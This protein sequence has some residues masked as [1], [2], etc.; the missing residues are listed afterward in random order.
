MQ[1]SIDFKTEKVLS[2][3][4]SVG[5]DRSRFLALIAC[6]PP[7]EEDKLILLRSAWKRMKAGE[8]AERALE[9]LIFVPESKDSLF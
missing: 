3:F 5:L 7:F 6:D 2:A 1:D 8:P 4:E 9:L